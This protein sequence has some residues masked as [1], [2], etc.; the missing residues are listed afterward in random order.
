MSGGTTP[1]IRNRKA[2]HD[3]EIVEK[4]EAGVVLSGTEVKSVRAGHVNL[5]DAHVSFENGQ[6]NLIGVTISEYVNKGYATHHATRPRRLLLHKKR[7]VVGHAGPS[8]R[9][10][11]SFRC[12]SIL[13]TVAMPRLK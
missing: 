11:R 10:T 4:L 9:A 3:Y 12:V 1:E 6:A 2:F 8:K 5:R 13:Q 7:S